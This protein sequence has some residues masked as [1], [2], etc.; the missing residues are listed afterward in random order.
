MSGAVVTRTSARD[1]QVGK[2][3]FSAH[4]DVDGHPLW[5]S[6]RPTLDL[7]VLVTPARRDIQ[8]AAGAR[9][10]RPPC[11]SRSRVDGYRL[12]PLVHVEFPHRHFV[13]TTPGRN[14]APAQ[15]IWASWHG[16]ITGGRGSDPRRSTKY[17]HGIAALT[18]RPRTAS[19]ATDGGG[20]PLRD[21]ST[22]T[23]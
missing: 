15:L 23:H 4:A 10:L 5:S 20:A 2:V 7:S 17:R 9:L 12:P 11:R 21:R 19:P 6:S 18:I 3:F 13:T 8:P 16:G 14:C 1:Q 22:S